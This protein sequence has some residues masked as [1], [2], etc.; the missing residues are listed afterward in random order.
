[1]SALNVAIFTGPGSVIAIVVSSEQPLLSVTVIVTF[2][3]YKLLAVGEFPIP[4][5]DQ[6]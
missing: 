5:T 3:A 2:P 4:D 6:L 1:M